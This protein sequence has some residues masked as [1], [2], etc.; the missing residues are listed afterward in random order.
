MLAPDAGIF[1][2]VGLSW[3]RRERAIL[4]LVDGQAILLTCISIKM[5]QERA[6]L[7]LRLLL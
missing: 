3:R 6:R 7:C 1:Q 4:S 5:E 2:R